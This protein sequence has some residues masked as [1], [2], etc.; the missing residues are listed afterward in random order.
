[1]VLLGQTAKGWAKGMISIMFLS[2]IV[3]AAESSV[4]LVSINTVPSGSG[5]QEPDFSTDPTLLR[6]Q[7]ALS[8]TQSAHRFIELGDNTKAIA[9]FTAARGWLRGCEPTSAVFEQCIFSAATVVTSLGE[10]I[11]GMDPP[12]ACCAGRET[13]SWVRDRQDL[14]SMART[15]MTGMAIWR[16]CPGLHSITQSE[17]EHYS[18]LRCTPLALAT[19]AESI[20]SS[21]DYTQGELFNNR[22]DV[23]YASAS[24]DL[25]M[26]PRFRFSPEL[27]DYGHGD[28]ELKQHI[29]EPTRL[30]IERKNM[31]LGFTEM[32]HSCLPLGSAS[33]G[34]R[35][36][37]K[38]VLLCVW[39]RHMELFSMVSAIFISTLDMHLRESGR[40]GLP[41]SHPNLLVLGEDP[42]LFEFRGRHYFSMQRV[43]EEVGHRYSETSAEQVFRNF[44]VDAETGRTVLL[45]K[46]D[47][48]EPYV[49]RWGCWA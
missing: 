6:L 17:M 33:A 41:K 23:P 10:L 40:L 18:S 21:F 3:S 13:L 42:R 24:H 34:A 11:V 5:V 39:R 27:W 2:S 49:C 15:A 46:P 44:L 36:A 22:T 20:I 28:N 31:S 30:Y 32:F 12:A 7:M 37:R 19:N 14:W 4:G 8:Y 38:P 9:C 29:E 45:K 35:P 47:M 43:T 1:M 48:G 26:I 16:T 25:K